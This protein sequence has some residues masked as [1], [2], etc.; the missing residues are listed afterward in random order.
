MSKNETLDT[1]CP[2]CARC[3]DE[4]STDDD[5]F[6]PNCTEKPERLKGLPIGMYHCPECGTMLVAGYPHGWICKPC[7]DR[8]HPSFD[9]A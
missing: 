8:T 1:M 9:G 3:Y 6:E 2:T 4:V 5:L 7:W